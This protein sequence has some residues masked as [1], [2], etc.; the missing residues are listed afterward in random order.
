MNVHSMVAPAHIVVKGKERE[1][2]QK[3]G[4]RKFSC[5][6]SGTLFTLYHGR[7]RVRENFFAPSALNV[8]E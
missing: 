6:W 7:L 2:H 8:N 1:F 4:A 5:E 3:S